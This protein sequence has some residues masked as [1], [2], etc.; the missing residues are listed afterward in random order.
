MP[1]AGF[2]DHQ[3]EVALSSDTSYALTQRDNLDG[4]A[5]LRSWKPISRRQFLSDVARLADGL[6]AHKF[7]VNLCTDRYRFM[8]GL[9]TAL[10]RRQIT[11]LPANDMERTLETLAGDYPD[12]YALTDSTHAHLPTFRYPEGEFGSPLEKV[13][14]PFFPADQPA[15]VL[16]TSG[17]TGQPKRIAKSWGVLVRSARSAGKRLGMAKFR[18]GTIIGTVPHQHSYGLESVILLALEHGLAVAAE[19]PFYPADIEAAIE[20]APPPRILV[21]TPVHIRALVAEQHA[22]PPVDLILSA[23]APLSVELAAKAEQCFRAPLVEIYGSSETGQIATRRTREDAEW[24]CLDAVRLRFQD[25]RSSVDGGA[26]PSPTHLDDLIEHTGLDTF[27]L[28]GR[29]AELVDIAGKHT[30]LSH[31]NHQ[32]LSIEGVRDGV[33]VFPEADGR[34]LRRLMAFVVA[35]GL[36]TEAILS[37]LRERVDQAFLPRPLMI[38]DRLPRNSLGKLSSEAVLQLMR[39]SRML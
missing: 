32:L 22:K 28:A 2:G 35:P 1:N 9:A 26:V 15:V 36:R 27:L 16:F 7:V 33:F 34:Y 38:V 8:V 24:R 10:L 18:G 25:G 20:A 21:T 13:E 3:G 11:L 23:T 29:S 12:V 37:A 4:L 6:P 19:R 14:V 17:T 39:Q 30:T 5:G 31:L